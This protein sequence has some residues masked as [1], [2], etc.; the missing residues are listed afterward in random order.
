MSRNDRNKAAS[1]HLK[2]NKF[3]FVVMLIIWEKLP[4]QISSADLK[5]I[6]IELERAMGKISGMR[7]K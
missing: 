5:S 7:D 3:E 1:L 2:L 6:K 4:I